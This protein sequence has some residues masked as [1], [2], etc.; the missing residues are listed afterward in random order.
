MGAT[1]NYTVSKDD[2]A[3]WFTPQVLATPPSG[4]E[5]RDAEIAT[6]SNGSVMVSFFQYNDTTGDRQSDR[7]R[8]N[9]CRGDRLR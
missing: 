2:G 9:L 5:Y 6:L 1:I 7:C 4:L 3:T 8:R